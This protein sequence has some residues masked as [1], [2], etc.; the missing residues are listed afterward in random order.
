VVDIVGRA[1]T[2]TVTL[3][4]AVVNF[5]EVAVIVAVPAVPVAL[6]V[7]DVVETLVSAV[8][9]APA[10]VQ[11]TPALVESLVT[12]AVKTFCC[13]RSIAWAALGDSVTLG[14]GLEELQLDKTNTIATAKM[15]DKFFIDFSAFGSDANLINVQGRSTAQQGGPCGEPKMAVW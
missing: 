13:P 10:Q 14:C 8:Q 5:I 12:A 7:A 4:A 11:L 1:L 2:V 6:N 15:S 3:E 9:A